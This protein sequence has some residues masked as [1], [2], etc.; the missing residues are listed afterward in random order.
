[1]AIFVRKLERR[2]ER[3]HGD[4]WEKKVLYP[5]N[6]VSEAGTSLVCSRK[7]KKYSAW[8]T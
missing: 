5:G 1:M 8:V 2:E 4:L 3:G 6:K 7:S